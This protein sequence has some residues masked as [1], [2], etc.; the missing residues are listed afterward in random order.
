MHLSEVG[1]GVDLL[2][3][4]ALLPG[5]ELP[6]NEETGGKVDFAGEGLGLEFVREG[7]CRHSWVGVGVLKS[8]RSSQFIA[9]KYSSS[10]MLRRK[11]AIVSVYVMGTRE[12]QCRKASGRILPPWPL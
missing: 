12:R 11:P 8:G 9:I 7:G 2:D 6:I 5:R 1:E 3:G 10:D 4:V